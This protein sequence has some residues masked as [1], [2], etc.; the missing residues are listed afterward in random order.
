MKMTNYALESWM[1]GGIRLEIIEPGVTL[2][3]KP[4]KIKPNF[5]FHISLN[6]PSGAII[7]SP[8]L[9]RQ[10][11]P[12]KFGVEVTCFKPL[13]KTP[14]MPLYLGSRIRLSI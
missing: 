13:P 5:G 8:A 12:L 10:V 14:V 6:E 3:S 4:Y 7:D 11:Q 9:P 2:S 1:F